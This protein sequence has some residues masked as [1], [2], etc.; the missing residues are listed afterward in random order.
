M[1]VKTSC[2]VDGC[3]LARD[4]FSKTDKPIISKKTIVTK[5][6]RE[7][8]KSFLITEV[9]VERK[10]VNGETFSPKELLKIEEEKISVP[11]TDFA[12]L[13]LD[14]VQQ[15]IKLLQTSLVQMFPNADSWMTT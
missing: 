1:L 7:V 2:L 6:V 3:I 9:S 12:S 15:F 4:I 14:T 5:E 11:E 13:Y 8:L 10:L